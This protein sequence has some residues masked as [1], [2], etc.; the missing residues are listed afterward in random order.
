MKSKVIDVGT[1]ISISRSAFYFCRYFDLP[2]SILVLQILASSQQVLLR[3]RRAR[4]P[5]LCVRR[6]EKMGRS[7]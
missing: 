2:D 3:P 4:R 5:D 1:T 7:G 6:L